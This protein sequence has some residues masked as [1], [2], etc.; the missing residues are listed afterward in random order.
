MFS[1]IAA[2]PASCIAQGSRTAGSSMPSADHAQFERDSTGRN[3]QFRWQSNDIFDIDA[4]SVAVAYC[5]LVVTDKQATNL[6]ELADVLRAESVTPWQDNARLGERAAMYLGRS[7]LAVSVSR[8]RQKATA[9]R[10]P[11]ASTS[12]TTTGRGRIARSSCDRQTPMSHE[13]NRASAKSDG[14][15][16]SAGSSTSTTEPPHKTRPE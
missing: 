8:F 11:S 2:A 12:T 3:P 13:R 14:A 7:S 6:D 4:L 9:R 10:R 5:D 1:S 15:T 16:D